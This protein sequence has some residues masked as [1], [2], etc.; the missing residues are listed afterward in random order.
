VQHFS[1][2]HHLCQYSRIDNSEALV[3]E[4]MLIVQNDGFVQSEETEQNPQIKK[5]PE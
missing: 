4:I 3:M 1:R 2:D 5:Y